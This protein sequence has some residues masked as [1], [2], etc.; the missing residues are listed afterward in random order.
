M[1]KKIS[2]NQ[3]D[4]GQAVKQLKTDS[5]AIQIK[6]DD[7]KLSKTNVHAAKPVIKIL[8]EVAQLTSEFSEYANSAA[9]DMTTIGEKIEAADN[10]AKN[11]VGGN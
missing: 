3:S 8:D 1:V 5:S 4:Y 6:L 7:V 2:Y 10:A 9:D 11:A